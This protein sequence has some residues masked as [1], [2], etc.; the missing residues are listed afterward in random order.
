[1][2]QR[3]KPSP[4]QLS[5]S[6]CHESPVPRMGAAQVMGSSACGMG[7]K[8]PGRVSLCPQSPLNCLSGGVQAYR[9]PTDAEGKLLPC[10]ST[11]FCCSIPDLCLCLGTA[12]AKGIPHTAAGRCQWGEN[13]L[14]KGV[15]AAHPWTMLVLAAWGRW[16]WQVSPPCQA[17]TAR[18]TQPEAD[19]REVT[20]VLGD[21]SWKKGGLGPGS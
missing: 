5:S 7:R 14:A 2:L 1:M 9:L 10:L 6:H 18:V 21:V 17:V 16:G 12:L 19:V 3:S 20:Q 8:K 15:P 4:T 11:T 13:R